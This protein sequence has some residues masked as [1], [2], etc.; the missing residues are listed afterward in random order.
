MP[1][2]RHEVDGK[3]YTLETS[4]DNKFITI[5][6]PI[7]GEKGPWVPI[8]QI[9]E[10]GPDKF[11]LSF[12]MEGELRKNRGLTSTGREI[13][14]GSD[15]E[16]IKQFDKSNPGIY[17][18]PILESISMPMNL[19]W[20][21]EVVGSVSDSIEDFENMILSFNQERFNA[22]LKELF[23]GTTF[24]STSPEGILARDVMTITQTREKKNFVSRDSYI[25]LV[26]LPHTNFHDIKVNDK[27][28]NGNFIEFQHSYNGKKYNNPQVK[29]N[30]Q[31]R[32]TC[33]LFF[34]TSFGYYKSS[35]LGPKPWNRIFGDEKFMKMPMKNDLYDWVIFEED[36]KGIYYIVPGR[37]GI[38]SPRKGYTYSS[39]RHL[40]DSEWSTFNNNADLASFLPIE[41]KKRI[42][43]E[44]VNSFMSSILDYHYSHQNK[45]SDI[46]KTIYD[47]YLDKHWTIFEI[48][49]SALIILTDILLSS[50]FKFE[51]KVDEDDKLIGNILNNNLIEGRTWASL[52]NTGV[53]LCRLNHFILHYHS[54][55]EDGLEVLESLYWAC[56]TVVKKGYYSSQKIYPSD[57]VHD[58]NKDLILVNMP[59]RLGNRTVP[60]AI[61]DIFGKRKGEQ[62]VSMYVYLQNSRFKDKNELNYEI[63]KRIPER[64]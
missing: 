50:D 16:I 1:T 5:H 43:E 9:K 21:K 31:F 39:G 2:Y 12:V 51:K 11:I 27:V 30:D 17:Q 22:F 42:E 56:L 55:E 52:R 58:P 28:V 14:I 61:I 13:V 26:F 57:F 23:S 44:T 6:S 33:L 25:K 32:W 36:V 60:E 59:F 24:S 3:T 41:R 45:F 15:S 18:P 7:T 10:M 46:F 37:H 40:E 47:G 54:N 63:W 34:V 4:K 29:L 62:I 38:S 53:K 19:S 20:F 49:T 35:P 8:R 48:A 64:D